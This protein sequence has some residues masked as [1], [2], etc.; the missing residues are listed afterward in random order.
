M[1]PADRLVGTLL[2]EFR[3]EEL[4][5][6]GAVGRVYRA[7]WTSQN[8]PVALKVLE[9]GICTPDDIRLR[10]LKEADLVQSFK[11]PHI[12]PVYKS[13]RQEDLHFIAMKLIRGSTLQ[14]ALAPEQ[15][16]REALYWVEQIASAL[17]FVHARE[18]VHRDIKPSN[19]LVEENFAYLTDF[20]LARLLEASTV[21]AATAMMG[22]P[23]YMSP[24]QVRREPVAPASDVF[25]MGIVLYALCTGIHPFTRRPADDP[26]TSSPHELVSTLD[27]IARCEFDPVPNLEPQVPDA[28]IEII[29]NCLQS[30]PDRRYRDAD[31]LHED[32][33]EAN[34]LKGIE[35]FDRYRRGRTKQVRA[36]T[37]MSTATPAPRRHDEAPPEPALMKLGKFRLRRLIGQGGTGK[38]YEAFQEDLGRV[39][40]LKVM[41]Q[42]ADASDSIVEQFMSEVRTAAKMS[43]PNILEVFE[44]G[45][46][47]G[48][49][50]YSMPLVQGKDLKRRATE[51]PIAP[52]RAMEIVRDAARAVQYAHE[53]GVIHCD[54]KPGNVL[55]D[56]SGHVFIADFGLARRKGE[57]V[58]GI[59]GTPAYMAPEQAEPGVARV[60]PA[61]D[62][63]G[64]GAVLYF[65]FTGRD[66]FSHGTLEAMILAVTREEPAPPIQFN[67]D[68][69]LEYQSVCRKAMAKDPSK[70]YASAADLAEALRA[71]M[72]A[73][74]TKRWLGFFKP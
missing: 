53:R 48:V 11:H 60:G 42:R 34:R 38:V 21:T 31:K 25:S 62:V 51:T 41:Q 19:I 71:A 39:V 54:L 74:P 69:P 2:D 35:A 66:P 52:R 17:A 55:V 70:R 40:A 43:H 61:T 9:D 37:R 26:G 24:E 29:M 68:L 65:L 49:L 28:L 64:L 23:L 18:V 67:S 73:R 14:A 63:Y 45:Q 1:G 58:H 27:R 13:G 8:K 30:D 72:N 3:I 59:V 32:L 10:F 33:A 46:Q 15:P 7:L 44:T 16:V 56:D 47:D 20:G 4:I 12:V 50:F 5:G 57:S 22:T 36:S 6:K